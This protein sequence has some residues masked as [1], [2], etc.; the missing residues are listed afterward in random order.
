MAYLVKNPPRVRQ[1]RPRRAGLWGVIGVHTAE[2][3]PDETG[4]D[5]GAEN[6]AR[7]IRDRTTPGCYHRLSDSDS[8]IELVPFELAT[9][10]IGTHGLNDRTIGIS[11]ATQAAKWRSLDPDYVTAM[12]Q[13]MARDAADAARWLKT[14]HGITVPA[15]RITLAQALN[16]QHGF[17]AH[18][19]AD[20]GRRTDP[21]EHFPWPLFLSTYAALMRGDTTTDD[22]WS[23]MAS[24]EEVEQASYEGTMRALADAAAGNGLT[25]LHERLQAEVE[26]GVA[27]QFVILID[28]AAN[29]S[30]A[31]G[32]ALSNDLWAITRGERG[33]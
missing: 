13:N 24:R 29:R 9:F 25:V 14:E 6:V 26:Q 23:E 30:T 5:T 16:G 15:R 28:E 3:F 1:F 17:L 12:V 18:G 10:H 8:R 4:P 33:E 32:R 22:E 2:S 20:P 31:R 11:A 21:G 7:F 27:R 19:D